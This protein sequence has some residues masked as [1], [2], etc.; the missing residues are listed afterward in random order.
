MRWKKKL[1]TYEIDEEDKNHK[2]VQLLD[3]MHLFGDEDKKR[4]G[5]KPGVTGLWQVIARSQVNFDDMVI[6]DYYYTQNIT[7][8]LDL[9]IILK[10]IPVLY[11]GIGAK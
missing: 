4:L 7:P 11:Y 1:E 2:L 9:K 6:L 3:T 10:T 5:L 8:W